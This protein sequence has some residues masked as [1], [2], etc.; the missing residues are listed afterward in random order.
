MIRAACMPDKA[1]GSGERHQATRGGEHIVIRQAESQDKA[2]YA[3]FLRDVSVEDLRLRFFARVGELSAAESD[4][5]SHL[6]Y[7]HEMAFI[8]LDERTGEML[9]LVRL[10]DELDEE[11]AEFAILVRSRL[12]GHGLGWLLM[13]R[14]IE[15]AKEKGLRRVYGDV[16]AENASMLQM[17]EEL[18]FHVENIGSGL[19]RVVLSLRSGE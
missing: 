4:R 7:S 5:L 1:I 16:L 17:A 11:T 14:V 18:G 13:Q 2:L 8:G 6:D 19:R 9:G 12:K 15:Y 10:K 3:D